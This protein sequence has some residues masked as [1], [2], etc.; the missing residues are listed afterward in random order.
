MLIGV[1]IYS[2][3]FK[4]LIHSLTS[5][6]SRLLELRLTKC[7][8]SSSEYCH[9][10]KAILTSNL[11]SF[12]SELVDICTD[13]SSAMGL[14]RAQIQSKTLEKAEVWAEHMRKKI[15]WWKRTMN[16]EEARILLEAI[17]YTNVKQLK[18]RRISK[19]AVSIE[20]TGEK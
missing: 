20:Q 12:T 15:D 8:I 19:D 7:T 6:H 11:T 16:N 2:G 5:P 14:P 3:C 17:N 10:I 9:L 13:V 18:I 4:V 1:S